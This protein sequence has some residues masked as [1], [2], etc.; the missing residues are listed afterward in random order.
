MPYSEKQF[1]SSNVDYV[2]K[3]FTSLKKTLIEYAKTYF[4][5]TYR[6]FNETSPGMM[7]IEM[8]AYVGDVL[9]FYIDQQYKEMMLPLAQERRN[10][11]Q[12]A[13][14]LGYKVKPNTPAYTTITATQTI[15]ADQSD[16][17]N[18][19]PKWSDAIVID[20]GL[21]ISSVSDPSIKF[22]TLNPIDF[23]SSG[24]NDASPEIASYDSDGLVA[25]YKLI[26]K[27]NAISGETKTQSF[28]TGTPQKF[29]RITLPEAN[30][31]DITKV[32][33]THGNT[34]YEVPYLAQDKVPIETWYA[35]GSRATAYTMTDGSVSE[36]SVPYTLQYLKTT[37]RF[38]TEINSDNTTSLVFGNGILRNGQSISNEFLNTEQAGVLIPGDTADYDGTL[39]PFLAND[40]ESLGETPANTTLT[41]TYRIGGGLKSNVGSGDLTDITR[42]DISVTNET[43][44]RGGS[45]G[46]TIEEIKANARAHFSTQ[47]RCVTQEDYEAR[48]L[49]MPSKFGRIAKIFVERGDPVV[50]TEDDA[51]MNVFNNFVQAYVLSYNNKK[52]LVGVD[53]NS[54]LLINMENYLEEHRIMTENIDVDNG[55]IINFGVAFEVVA[56]RSAIKSVV[57]LN[58][59]KTIE[60]YFNIDKMQFRQP[61]YTSDLIYEIMGLD[62]VRAVNFVELTQ[63][64]SEGSLVNSTSDIDH[65]IKLWDHHYDTETGDAVMNVNTGEYGWKYD[66]NQF[67]NGNISNNGTILPSTDPSV[68]ELKYPNQNIQGRVL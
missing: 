61:L 11:M 15:D 60:N 65:T 66:F 52:H 36:I 64:F 31:V 20:N 50:S 23:A 54:Y 2:N 28:Q 5:N 13:N 7:L 43:P 1:K 58:C 59:I 53:D 33:D 21:Q 10:I 12:M 44:A 48:I 19:T 46:E 25:T 18:I 34:W 3:D 4:P 62:G 35:S 24:S 9:S 41:V 42:T 6:D 51:T 45:E 26:R 30:V 17:N 22:E 29:Y 47:N 38:I 55:Y 68:F 16:T 57:K 56:H 49:A 27:V 37:K 67:Y 8:S 14:M 32:E 63:D 40:Y 39:N